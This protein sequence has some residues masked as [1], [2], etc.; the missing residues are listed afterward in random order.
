[1]KLDNRNLDYILCKENTDKYQGT[2]RMLYKALSTSTFVTAL[3]R[4]KGW[5]WI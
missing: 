4:S 2:S 1:M 3:S 5:S